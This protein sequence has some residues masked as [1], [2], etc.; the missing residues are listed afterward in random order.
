MTLALSL[1]SFRST[2]FVWLFLGTETT[3]KNPKKLSKYE[4]YI[5]IFKIIRFLQIYYFFPENCYSYL[6]GLTWI[7]IRYSQGWLESRFVD[8]ATN[9]LPVS[10]LISKLY[11]I[12]ITFGEIN[13][14]FSSSSTQSFKV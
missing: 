5:T 12:L 9:P 3:K 4:S 6:L 10:A 7:L 2:C 11:K 13:S 1:E 14:C 8:L